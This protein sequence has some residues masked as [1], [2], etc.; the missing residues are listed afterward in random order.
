ATLVGRGMAAPRPTPPWPVSGEPGSTRSSPT[1]QPDRAGARATLA[2]Y[3]VGRQPEPT[4]GRAYEQHEPAASAR[5]PRTA[6]IRPTPPGKLDC[7]RPR[8]LVRLPKPRACSSAGERCLHT[9]EVAGSKPATPTTH[10]R[11]SSSM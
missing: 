11:R 10:Y 1:R 2:P 6:P 7:G 9:A 4:P 8:K 5:L 3:R